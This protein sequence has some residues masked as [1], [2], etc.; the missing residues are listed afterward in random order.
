MGARDK[1]RN[2]MVLG[3]NSIPPRTVATGFGS[4]SL[5]SESE[6]RPNAQVRVRP[7]STRNLLNDIALYLPVGTSR[8]RV[9]P[10]SGGWTLRVATGI[11]ISLHAPGRYRSR[12]LVESRSRRVVG[13]RAVYWYP[14]RRKRSAPG[15]EL[16]L[17]LDGAR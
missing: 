15:L 3:W 5:R 17:A 4:A 12:R 16:R 8:P 14:E 11:I 6:R 1:A 13:A 10:A 2:S 9:G 7:R